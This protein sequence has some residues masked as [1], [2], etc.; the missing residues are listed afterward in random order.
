MLRWLLVLIL[1]CPLP[2]GAQI[3]RGTVTDDGTGAIIKAV[4]LKLITPDGRIVYR[5]LSDDRGKFELIIPKGKTVYLQAER[6]GFETVTSAALSTPT[7]ELIEVNVRLS[8]QAIAMKG[9]EVVARKPV[10][11]RLRPF[12]DRA[13]LYKRAGI[14]RIWTRAD[15]EKRHLVFVSTLLRPI[16]HRP[17]LD[18]AGEAVFI[19]DLPAETDDIDLLVAPEDLEGVEVYRDP[20]VPAD[21]LYRAN[22]N[23]FGRFGEVLP[24]CRVTMLWRKP[25]AELYAHPVRTWRVAIGVGLIGV[26]Y[27]LERAMW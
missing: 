14:G 9:I 6:I 25:Y 27:V 18:C 12:M 13:S 1:A 4:D 22:L 24:P 20:D 26:L 16:P 10:E 8:P 5:V 2:A 7:V 3:I 19:D 17:A 15:L 21:L 11:W 23:S